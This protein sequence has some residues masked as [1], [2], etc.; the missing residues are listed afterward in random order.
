MAICETAAQCCIEISFDVSTG[1]PPDPAHE[2]FC[3]RA[4][5]QSTLSRRIVVQ[6][7][8][9]DSERG[10]FPEP[11]SRRQSGANAVRLARAGAMPASAVGL[12]SLHVSHHLVVVA[13]RAGY[14]EV[15]GF[16]I[17][18]RLLLVGRGR[19]GVLRV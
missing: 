17:G 8:H 4:V 12:G 14:A 18:L 6:L 11:L 19:C 1:S 13:A 7:V 15:I 2:R 10:P 5:R 16:T 9:L 3:F